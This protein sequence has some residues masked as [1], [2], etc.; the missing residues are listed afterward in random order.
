MLEL[1]KNLKLKKTPHGQILYRTNDMYLGRSLDLYDEFSIGEVDFFK[2]VITKNMIVLDIGANIGVLTV[3]M[4]R[5]AQVVIS[6]EAERRLQQMCC[7]NVALNDLRNVRTIHAAVGEFDGGIVLPSID[8]DVDGNFGCMEMMGHEKGNLVQM[9]RIDSMKLPQCDFM[10]ID[11]EGMERDVLIGAHATIERFRP[12]IYIENDRKEKSEQLIEHLLQLDYRVHWHLP[13]LFRPDNAAGNP[14]NVFDGIASMNMICMPD[15][16]KIEV[17]AFRILN[18][19]DWW[20]N[21]VIDKEKGEYWY[22]H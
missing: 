15:D 21:L 2:T 5:L 9:L 18:N 10:K 1:A 16:R 22:E 3:E 19:T 6:F 17:S 14:E 7:A 20:S 12:I 13:Y 4:A 8:F 11:V